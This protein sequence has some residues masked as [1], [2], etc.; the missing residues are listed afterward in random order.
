MLPAVPYPFGELEASL[1]AKQVQ[2]QSI[3]TGKLEQQGEVVFAADIEHGNG[4]DHP[5]V[6]GKDCGCQRNDR[7]G[8]VIAG[9]ILV[10]NRAASATPV[11]N[12]IFR[13][14]DDQSGPT[15]NISG[16]TDFLC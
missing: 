1:V 11:I 13:G 4:R 7:T 9:S 16:K 3:L 14:F 12:I 15:A 5:T 10:G 8:R 6:I 2:I